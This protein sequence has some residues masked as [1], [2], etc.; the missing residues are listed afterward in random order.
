VREVSGYSAFKT[1]LSRFSAKPAVTIRWR[2]VAGFVMVLPI[3]AVLGA[4][5][6]VYDVAAST[7]HWKITDWFLHFAMR[8][9]VR[10]HALA[11]EEPAKLPEAG[12]Q[13]AAGHFAI[14]CAVCHG[15][16][17]EPR[18]QAMLRMLP[19]PPDLA[20]A[21]GTWTDAQLFRIVKHG[22][23]FTGMPAWP[24][25]DRDGEVWGMV[26][27]LRKL[28]SLSPAEYRQLAYGPGR[29]QRPMASL[30]DWIAD[31]SRCHG[32]EGLGRSALVPVIA[33]QSEAYLLESLR[34]YVRRSRPSGIMAV[35]ANGLSDEV[36]GSLAR[37]YA[38]L[39]GLSRV[40]RTGSG[41]M[42]RIKMEEGE[43]I[44]V[45]GDPSRSIPACLGCHG[46]DRRPQY[47]RLFGQ[48][49]EY[50]EE[51]LRLFRERK[52]TG[53]RFSHLMWN[54]AHR[55]TDAEIAAVAA[56]F[57]SEGGAE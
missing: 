41:G 42:A 4:W 43:R 12:V 24:T 9:S 49:A 27:F 45:Q 16:P 15:A 26:A 3:L 50:M 57:A 38:G 30:E 7:G 31:C 22:V 21:V 14:A 19:Y 33:G 17:G 34:A 11:V 29:S 20:S 40:P 23:R 46:Q 8:S 2:H 47:P 48:R 51:Q 6:G 13:P 32:K 56:Y 39:P 53:S 28:P 18:T 36:V 35:A 52:R 5:S 25:Q 10:T 37:H 54:A 44:A 55:L 1:W